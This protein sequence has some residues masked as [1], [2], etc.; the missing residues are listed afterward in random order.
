METQNVFD[1]TNMYTQNKQIWKLLM[2]NLWSIPD[3]QTSLWNVSYSEWSEKRTCFYH[4]CCSTLLYNTSLED[5]RK[6]AETK[7]EWDT[8]ASGLCLLGKCI[9]SMN[10]NREV[11]FYKVLT[12]R[13]IRIFPF[14]TLKFKT[15]HFW[16][17]SR[18]WNIVC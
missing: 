3:R 17:Q 16:D 15:L 8:S 12:M 5:P 10:R 14:Y 7:I 13:Y 9:N 4:H 1:V 18:P 6:P 2:W 11:V